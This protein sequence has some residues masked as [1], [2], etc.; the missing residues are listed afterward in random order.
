MKRLAGF[1]QDQDREL[2]RAAANANQTGAAE[3][4]DAGT[5]V[6]R[7]LTSVTKTRMSAL[8]L[9]AALGE[10]SDGMLST[11]LSLARGE[12]PQLGLGPGCQGP[13]RQHG[14]APAVQQQRRRSWRSPHHHRR[15]GERQ[16]AEPRRAAAHPPRRLGGQ[17]HAGEGGAAAE[18]PRRRQHQHQLPGQKTG[19]RPCTTWRGAGL[20]RRGSQRCRSSI[21]SSPGCC[22]PASTTQT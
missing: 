6:K 2:R 14:H 10:S 7:L 15:E 4:S 17:P 19:R 22:W 20:L 16:G 18:A 8:H 5:E 12:G 21:R 9:A 1:C 13:G 11:L 3:E